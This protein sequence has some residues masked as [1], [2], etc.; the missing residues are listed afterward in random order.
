VPFTQWVDQTPWQAASADVPGFE[1]PV[2]LQIANT[3]RPIGHRHAPVRVTLDEFEL[4]PYAGDF[5]AESA[6]RDFRSHLTIEQAGEDPHQATV[7]LNEPHYM[8]VPGFLGGFSGQSWLLFQNQWDP[9]NQ[10]FTVLGVGNRPGIYPMVGGCVMVV[11]GLMW[12]FYVKPVILRRRKQ[13]A[14]AAHLARSD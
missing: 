3:R 5:T 13:A 7:K 14:L 9:E 12:A 6:M 1:S 10:A 11:L 4:V 2:Q 8:T